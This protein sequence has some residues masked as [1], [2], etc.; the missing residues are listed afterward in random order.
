MIF[1]GISYASMM[2]QRLGQCSESK[3]FSKSMKLISDYRGLPL[4]RLLDNVAQDEYLLCVASSLSE[5]CL[6][7]S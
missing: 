1:A 6:F 7:C 5:S 4:I 3:A 2:S